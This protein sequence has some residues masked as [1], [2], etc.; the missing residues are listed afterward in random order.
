V[1]IKTLPNGLRILF[2]PNNSE[3]GHFA[4]LVHAGTRD[5][6]KGKEGL[7]HF[8]E[9]TVF[10]GTRKRNVFQLL[11]R[12]DAVGGELNAF[13]SKEE[14]CI[15]GSFHRRYLVRAIELIADIVQNATF[16]AAEL[17]K[18][19]TVI[20]EEIRSYLDSPAEQIFDDFEQQVFGKH[21]LAHSILGTEDSLKNIKR[22]DVVEFIQRYYHP[23]N[24]VCCVTGP[25][26]MQDVVDSV[27]RYFNQ[28]PNKGE[29]PV[30]KKPMRYHAQTITLTRNFHQTHCIIGASAYS[31]H[32]PKR[33]P[34]TLLM[35]ILG[36]PAMNAKLHLLIREKYGLA[37][38]IDAGYTTFMDAGLA[39]IYLG[40]EPDNLEC[41]L[42]L[43]N[44][45]I[46]KFSVKKISSWALR[47]AQIQY[48]GQLTM[49]EENKLSVLLA[50]GRQLLQYNKTTTLAEM[51]KNIRS[52]RPE[53]I[54]EVANEILH[55]DHLSHLIY[56]G[57][58]DKTHSY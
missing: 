53:Q 34:L 7:A 42:D 25:Y 44:R 3:T 17:E 54:Q 49:A 37:Y 12:L 47:S 32:H 6:E 22:K 14:T 43:V 23:R 33:V 21:P 57:Q 35:N 26:Q 13:T 30:R 58:S 9:H 1:N 40:T 46:K 27:S 48:E 45:E 10:K 16:P 4:I 38:T 28:L 39:H 52:I 11:S 41:C 15:Y 29:L 18:E 31:T 8:I 51:C 5:E 50:V 56:N 19:K 24:M 2:R 55:P 36:G 20:V